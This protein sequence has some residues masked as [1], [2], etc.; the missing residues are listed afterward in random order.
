MK[1][2][3]ARLLK[4]SIE[5]L[6]AILNCDFTLVFDNGEELEVDDHST[7]YTRYVWELFAE[8]PETRILP[9]HHFFKVLNGSLPST[10]AHTKLLGN[11][12]WSIY[13]T[14]GYKVKDPLDPVIL[15]ETLSRRIYE[16]TNKIYNELTIDYG[17]WVTTLALEDLQEVR[18]FPGIKEIFEDMSPEEAFIAG[19]YERVNKVLIDDVNE[20]V[21]R[22]D[23]ESAPAYRNKVS[24]FLRSSIVNKDQ[25]SQCNVFRGHLKEINGRQYPIPIM[26]SYLE[27]KL[28][29]YAAAIESRSSSMALYAT[30]KPLQ[31]TET[32]NRLSQLMAMSLKYMIRGDC[33][34]TNYVPWTVRK[35]DLKNMVGV[36]YL[37]EETGKIEYIEKDDVHL[38]D[39]RLKLR[40]PFGCVDKTPG[41][42]CMVCYGQLSHHFYRETNVGMASTT[43]GNGRQSQMVISTKH[44]DKSSVIAPIVMSG[45]GVKYFQMDRSGN[46]IRFT[47]PKDVEE[48][49]L[50]INKEDAP[51]FV[52]I[53]DVD[54]VR[55]LGIHRTSGMVEVGVEMRFRGLRDR[56]TA[57]IGQEKRRA[58]LTHEMLHYIKKHGYTMDQFGNYLIDLKNW[59]DGEKAF[60]IP[61]RDVSVGDLV[62]TYAKMIEGSKE[63]ANQR[64]NEITIESFLVE[65]F[66]LINPRIGVNLQIIMATLY[67]NM[68]I[69][70]D[71]TQEDYGIPKGFTRAGLGVYSTTIRKRSLG[72]TMAFQNHQSTLI[73]PSNFTQTNR[74]DS[75]L[76]V[77]IVPEEVV[78]EKHVKVP[79]YS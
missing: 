15:L 69:N 70:A 9:K 14:Y 3:A 65:L 76:D 5:E 78:K 48:S 11:V 52:D 18:T 42:V 74:M 68:V 60:E 49:F 16:I 45:D 4:F 41:G 24:R 33:G 58:S 25:V 21:R 2:E 6:K 54:D 1:I 20:A 71:P 61:R 50:V 17:D 67:A 75:P 7:I 44:I 72:A 35:S 79:Y 37:D 36:N 40:N 73:D 26:T 39:K 29:A 57:V 30:Q 55:R 53:D 59:K 31:K 19:S 32:Y 64:N 51:G 56:P 12:F 46:F 66:D 62:A 38:V 13:F 22:G 47:K 27:G 77:C 23:P 10:G 43:E 34:S 28:S 63:N 8:Y